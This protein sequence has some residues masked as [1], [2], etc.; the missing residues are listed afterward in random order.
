MPETCVVFLCGTEHTYLHC[1][2]YETDIVE[3]DGCSYSVK[4]RAQN[5]EYHESQA[6]FATGLS[7]LST[8]FIIADGKDPYIYPGTGYKPLYS[9]H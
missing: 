1:F 6:H 4:I 2:H 3:L 7:I 5:R 8:E 9:V